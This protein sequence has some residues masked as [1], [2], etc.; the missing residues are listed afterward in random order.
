MFSF[1]PSS[2]RVREP[3]LKRWSA[4][5][6]PRVRAFG[7]RF[8]QFARLLRARCEFR[9]AGIPASEQVSRRFIDSGNECQVDDEYPVSNSLGGAAPLLLQ[10]GGVAGIQIA[11]KFEAE[12]R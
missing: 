8:D 1:S 3:G 6:L 10:L 4:R 9:S 7:Y 2:C 11:G 5:C 12:R